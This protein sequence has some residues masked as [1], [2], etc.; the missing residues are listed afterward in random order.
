MKN[1]LELM[2]ASNNDLPEIYCDMDQVLCDFIG[3]AEKAIGGSFVSTDKNDQWNKITQTK[4]F[5][6]DLDWVPGAKR[7]YSFISKYDPHIL[8]IF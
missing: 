6:E 1:L 8:S 5:W 7:L 3:G 2:E 4:D